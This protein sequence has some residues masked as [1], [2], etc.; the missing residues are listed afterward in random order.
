MPCPRETAWTIKS[1]QTQQKTCPWS[2]AV[3]SGVRISTGLLFLHK[4]WAIWIGWSGDSR[5]GYRQLAELGWLVRSLNQPQESVERSVDIPRCTLT[6]RGG[7]TLKEWWLQ[8]TY[9]FVFA[10]PVL[11]SCSFL[12]Q[13]FAWGEQWGEL[14]STISVLLSCMF[15][16]TTVWIQLRLPHPSGFCCYQVD[17]VAQL[18]LLDS[19]EP[20]PK[21]KKNLLYNTYII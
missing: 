20:N 6:V 15:D 9:G 5:D 14:S 16:I 17:W 4:P 13:P 21:E 12:S 11:W 7:Y 3:W 2:L 1:K 8:P 18:P 19:W 10:R